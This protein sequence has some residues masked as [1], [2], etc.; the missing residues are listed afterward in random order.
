MKKSW[1]TT[2]F[3]ISTIIGGVAMIITKG[4]LMEGVTA[5]TTGIGIVFAK[6]FNADK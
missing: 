6:D 4:A 3:G 5:I 2:F 1:K